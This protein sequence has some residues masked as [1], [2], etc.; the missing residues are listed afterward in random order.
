MASITIV[1]GCPGTGKTTLC[2]RL[3]SERAQGM[4]LVAD[5]FYEAIA[6][7]I[8]PTRPESHQQNTTVTIATARAAGVFASGDYEVFI[9]GLVGP[10]F[11]PVFV[12]ELLATGVPLHYVVLRAGLEETLARSEGRDKSV[13][14]RVVR[15]MH[16]A[17]ADLGELE[18]HALD[19]SG[20]SEAETL[21]ELRRRH[22]A[23][24]LLLDLALY[25]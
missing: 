7:P 18:R 22:Q 24:E 2:Q 14:E 15:R 19:C 20:Q 25:A 13:P 9:D 6:N 16:A 11:V 5:A 8:D 10:W 4:H 23:D 21:V 12:R 17:F 1:S 3:A